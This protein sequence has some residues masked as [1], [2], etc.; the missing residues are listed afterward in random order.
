MKEKLSIKIWSDIKCPFCYI[1]KVKFEK[2]LAE[3]PHK[4]QVEV[5]WKSFQ[6]EPDL[7]TEIHADSTK[8]FSERKGI[9]PEQAKQMYENVENVAQE[10]G[11]NFNLGDT[12]VANSFM[13]HRFIQFAQ[14]KGLG[15]EAEEALFKLH[16][17]DCEN[18]DDAAH[19]MNIGLDL[20]LEKTA[21]KHLFDS[22][23]FSDVVHQDIQEAQSLGIQ[24]VP[25]FV[26]NDQYGIS[27]AQS[28]EVFLQALNQVWNEAQV[29][30]STSKKDNSGDQSCTTDGNCD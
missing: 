28:S 6:L 26:L 18:I 8:H 24:G 23:E 1:G 10:V 27:G 29:K 13:A 12:V 7:K 17:T 5:Q 19:L 25:Y 3:F 14:T 22:S 11:L 9:S 15:N 2:A 4:N 16:F 20:G 21:L 30:E